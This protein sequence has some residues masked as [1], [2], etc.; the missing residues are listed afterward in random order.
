MTKRGYSLTELLVVMGMTNVVLLVGVG[1]VHRVM[2]EQKS[3]DRD[4][5]MQRVAER[6]S[7]R[8]REDV[9]LAARAELIE[10]DEEG[11]QRLVLNQPGNRMV[12][13]TVRDS[14]L[15]RVATGESG[16][17]HRDS[18]RFPDNYRLQ[19]DDVPAERVSFTAY[20][21]PAAYLATINVESRGMAETESTVRRAVMHVDAG[22]GRDHRFSSETR[23]PSES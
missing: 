22:L 13:Y 14:D 6:L 7:T 4:N 10:L 12:T 21:I 1:T 11:A 20:A 15:E 5:A 16:P 2:H 3:A 8:L 19:F 23:K 17:T 18:F 9:H